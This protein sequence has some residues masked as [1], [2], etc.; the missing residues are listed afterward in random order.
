[1]YHMLNH[2]PRKSIINGFSQACLSK[3]TTFRLVIATLSSYGIG[4]TISPH[5]S[6][7]TE[8]PFSTCL[9]FQ[10]ISLSIQYL[11]PKPSL[12][13][14]T[15]E[16]AGFDHLPNE[17]I[18]GILE[19]VLPQD[20]EN[21]AQTSKRVSLL[22]QPF[23]E[24]HRQLIR[25]YSTTFKSNQL[26]R[27]DAFW[28][29]PIPSLLVKIRNEPR[30]AHYVR[31]V[32]L[33]YSGPI[34]RNYWYHDDREG[35]GKQRNLVDALIARSGVPNLQSCYD[36]NERFCF[37]SYESYEEFL[38]AFFL[39]LLPNLNRLSLPWNSYRGYFP[40]MI[41]QSALQGNGWFAHL[42]TVRVK[43]GF[44]HKNLGIRDL[45]LFSSLPALKSLVALNALDH[46]LSVDDFLPPTDSHTKTLELYH[47][48][49][50]RITI[51]WYIQSFQSLQTFTLTFHDYNDLR[52]KRQFD[53]NMVRAALLAHAKTTLHSLTIITRSPPGPHPSM[54]SLQP[55]EALQ[56]LRTQWT[57]LFPSD[58][59]L[60]TCPSQILPPSIRELQL[61][62]NSGYTD[63]EVYSAL[64]QGLR[65]AKEKTCVHLA[66]VEIYYWDEALV[67]EYRALLRG[68][69][70]D[71]GMKVAFMK[72]APVAE[73]RAGPNVMALTFLH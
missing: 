5:P 24:H 42:T 53:P 50:T 32:K 41:R 25:L 66:L 10:V 44:V 39:L 51:Y 45:S 58:S 34:R 59:S 13:D 65:C 22:A 47:S 26:R 40:D 62:D 36:L 68:L 55:F 71:I 17:I 73:W 6:S 28:F 30:I 60:E 49:F 19:M 37:K 46:G 35:Y 63:G 11:Q 67:A 52:I 54:A 64:C 31:E 12:S 15:R 20:L 61:D 3:S 1:M 56:K 18:L 72:R 21:L 23:L 43:G 9:H 38:V 27:D 69:C 4:V 16:M 14:P 57:I 33:E 8:S 48:Y 2:E 29:A 7:S 70:R